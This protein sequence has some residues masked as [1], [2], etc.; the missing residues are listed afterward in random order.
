MA[1]LLGVRANT[2]IATAFALSGLLAGVAAIILVEQTGIMQ[3]TIGV[4]PVLAAF[5][6]T[7]L[8]GLGSLTGAVIGGYFL[9]VIYGRA[10][11]DAAARRSGRTETP[12]Y[13]GSCWSCSWCG[14]RGCSSTARRTQ[15]L[16]GHVKSRTSRSRCPADEGPRV[17]SLAGTLLV[18]VAVVTGLASLGSPVLQN[19]LVN[20]LINLIWSSGSTSSSATP[21][22]SRSATSGSWRSARTRRASSASPSRSRRR[23]SNFR[24][25]RASRTRAH[26]RPCCSAAAVAALVAAVSRCRSCGSAGYR[27]ARHIRRAQHHLH[28]SR[29]TGTI[30]PAARPAWRGSRR[31][32]RSLRR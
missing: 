16:S 9:G 30:S 21:A 29:R 13:S 7:I 2:V 28:R 15:G 17:G 5:V 19:V 22:C 12:S 18:L 27:R 3:P 26:C 10:A 23:C 1:R 20:M 14:R 32:R 31:R 25:A 11:G 4:T 6:A 24:A 8:G